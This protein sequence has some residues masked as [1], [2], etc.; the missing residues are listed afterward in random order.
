ML[1]KFSFLKNGKSEKKEQVFSDAHRVPE[2]VAIIMDGNGRWAQRRGLPRIAGHR[3]ALKTIKKITN[4]A[5]RLGVKVLTLYAFS[6]ENWKR[7]KTE[8]EFLMKLPEQFLNSYLVELIENNVQVRV[9]GDMARIPAH[10][11]RAVNQAIEKTKKNSGLVLNFA[12][13]YGSHAE[14]VEAVRSLVRDALDHKI[15]PDSIDE[16]LLSE[17]MLSPLL[18]DPDLLIRTGGEI[19]L[20]NFMLW[21]MAYTELYFTEIY[22]PDFSE[23]DLRTAIFEFSTRQRR[24]GGIKE[25]RNGDK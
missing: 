3:E 8:V 16:Q 6:T 17:R 20:S 18:P 12:L 15:E 14:I 11:I 24:Y 21:Q 23:S 2:H 19:R 10:T 25:E 4:E 22:W 9:M 13:N 5:Q 7:P 1:G